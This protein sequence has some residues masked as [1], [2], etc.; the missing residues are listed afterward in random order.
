[1]HMSNNHM[2]MSSSAVAREGVHLWS[3]TPAKVPQRQTARQ[4]THGRPGFHHSNT[5]EALHLAE[6]TVMLHGWLFML[7]WL[8]QRPGSQGTC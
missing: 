7:P 4:L 1:M 2:C 6:P 5:A 3:Y 8:H